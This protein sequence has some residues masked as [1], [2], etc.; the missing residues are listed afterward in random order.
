MITLE[1]LERERRGRAVKE[2][3]RTQRQGPIPDTF[4]FNYETD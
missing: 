1:I 4:T 3:Y 2:V